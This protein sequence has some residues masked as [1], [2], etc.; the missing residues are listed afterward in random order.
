MDH[1]SATGVGAWVTAAGL[2]GATEPELLC[3]FCER[4]AFVSVGRYALRGVGQ[5]QDLFT[6]EREV[7][8]LDR[9]GRARPGATRRD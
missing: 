9:R 8:D 4:A 3:G 2:A 1:A 5:A 6:L 7:E